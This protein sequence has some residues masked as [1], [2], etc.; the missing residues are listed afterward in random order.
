MFSVSGIAVVVGP[1]S[2]L[3]D[4]GQGVF[5]TGTAMAITGFGMACTDA[6]DVASSV[7]KDSSTA[8]DF[9][10]HF[11]VKFLEGSQ[12]SWSPIQRWQSCWK[13]SP[14]K[15]RGVDKILLTEPAASSTPGQDL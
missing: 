11:E 12:T 14:S 15:S 7:G 10:A 4:T 8:S 9:D 13:L 2:C 1:G 5:G 6:G 3:V